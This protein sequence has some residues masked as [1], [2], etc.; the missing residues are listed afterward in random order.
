MDER[1]NARY[2]EE[3]APDWVRFVRRGFDASRDLVNAPAFFAM[4]PEVRGL[5]G[6]DLGCGEGHN[7]RLC[8]DRGARMTAL[9]IAWGMLGPAAAQERKEPRGVHHLRGSSVALPFG[10]G[11]FNFVVAFMSLM[12]M[13]EHARVLAEV[14]RVLRPGGF[15]QLAMTHPCFQTPMWQWLTDPVGRRRAIICG[16]YFRE[17]DGHVEEWTFGSALPPGERPRPFRIPRFTHTLSTWLNLFID[18]G[19]MLERFAEPTLDDATAAAHPA[20]CYD[21]RIIAYFLTMR[22]RKPAR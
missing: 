16:D 14:N 18:A 13:P 11:A 15:F 12:D 20:K 22:L 9:D 4:L 19:F 6:L 8:A 10:D 2:W 17:L 3:N 21:T 5:S 7:A 1:E